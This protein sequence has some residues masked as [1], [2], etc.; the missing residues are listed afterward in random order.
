M[1]ER[2]MARI[3]ISML[4]IFALSLCVQDM[5]GVSFGSSDS[6]S[7][8]AIAMIVIFNAWALLKFSWRAM[9]IAFAVSGFTIFF[10]VALGCS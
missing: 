7:W 3:L 10:Y 9:R 5:R 4:A 2:V 6:R 8:G 1:N